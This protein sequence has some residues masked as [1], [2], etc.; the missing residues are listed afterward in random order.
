MTNNL[1]VHDHGQAD[2][3]AFGFPHDINTLKQQNDLDILSNPK[4]AGFGELMDHSEDTEG[5]EISIASLNG[6]SIMSNNKRKKSEELQEACLDNARY[7]FGTNNGISA[8]DFDD[9]E[10]SVLSLPSMTDLIHRFALRDEDSIGSC[11]WESLDWQTSHTNKRQ[12]TEPAS[13]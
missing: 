3:G 4:L 12:K 6:Y 5:C 10:Q 9:M 7:P 1:D 2:S 13:E 11:L 8:V